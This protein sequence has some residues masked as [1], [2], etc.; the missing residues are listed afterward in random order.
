MGAV[1]FYACLPGS[2]AYVAIYRALSG[3]LFNPFFIIIYQFSDQQK[4]NWTSHFPTAALHGEPS[5]N[6]I[7]ICS[8]AGQFCE[9]LATRKKTFRQN[10]EIDFSALFSGLFIRHFVRHLAI[11]RIRLVFHYQPN[12]LRS[13]GGWK[14]PCTEFY[15]SGSLVFGRWKVGV[16]AGVWDYFPK[17]PRNKGIHFQQ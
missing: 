3:Q 4:Q 12:Q 11:V 14:W 17:K 16:M 5:G 2:D 7:G 1:C 15:R 8:Y 10:F 13:T 9:P 6:V